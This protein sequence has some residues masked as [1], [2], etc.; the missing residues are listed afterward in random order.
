MDDA[1][2]T[3]LRSAEAT[4]KAGGALVDIWGAEL[5]AMRIDILQGKA[6]DVLP[7]IEKRLAAL[8]AWWQTSRSIPN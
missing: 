2:K 8:R 7:G 3:Y 4:K 6:E 5:E 1:R